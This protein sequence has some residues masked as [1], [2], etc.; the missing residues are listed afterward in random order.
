M[1]NSDDPDFILLPG[2]CEDRPPVSSR[3][4]RALGERGISVAALIVPYDDSDKLAIDRTTREAP[5]AVIHHINQVAGL[6]EDTPRHGI[7][8]SQGG[9]GLLITAKEEPKLYR[10]IGAIAPVGMNNEVLGDNPKQRTNEFY[11]RLAR[12][13][14]LPDQQLWHRGNFTAGRELGA[15]IWSDLR[16][17]DGRKFGEL[18]TAKLHY[19]MEQNLA[20]NVAILAKDRPVRIFAG[21]EDPVFKLAELAQALGHVSC[22]N[23]LEVVPGSHISWATRRGQEQLLTAV[24]WAESTE[25]QTA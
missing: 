17:R 7:D 9:G 24:R 19:A 8:H 12:N 22:G 15:G 18:L 11:Q 3:V 14:F 2:L 10:A 1:S 21:D 6:P 25:A 5:I 20:E 16:G 13:V 23:S 4:I